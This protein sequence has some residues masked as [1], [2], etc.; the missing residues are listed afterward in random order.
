[1]PRP[2]AQ[3]FPVPA[4]PRACAG[5]PG[6]PPDLPSRLAPGAQGP[7]PGCAGVLH[8]L[9]RGLSTPSPHPEFLCRR[10]FLRPQAPWGLC[11]PSTKPRLPLRRPQSSRRARPAHPTRLRG[12]RGPGALLQPAGPPSSPGGNSADLEKGGAL[13]HR[14]RARVSRGRP[15]A[16]S[17]GRPARPH[18]A[19][20]SARRRR[21]RHRPAACC[22]APASAPAPAQPRRAGAGT[23][24]AQAGPGRT[25]PGR[26]LPPAKSPCPCPRAKRGTSRRCR[27]QARRV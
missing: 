1:M 7:H 9:G 6:V 3:P 16:R 25:Q 23:R 4:A 24:G 5:L 13:E 21:A 15:G 8:C 26:G 22:L 12:S 11:A 20:P 2:F 18:P 10:S 27:R 19:V 17:V 14:N